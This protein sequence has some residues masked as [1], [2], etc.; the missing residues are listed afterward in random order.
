[1]GSG[2]K[3]APAP[4][5]ANP[6]IQQ[7]N[8]PTAFETI[9]N[10]RLKAFTDWENKPGARDILEAPGIGDMVDIYGSA[11]SL[12]NQKRLGNP[13]MAL[14]SGGSR[15]YA[16]QLDS[17][18]TQNRYDER[19]AGLSRGVASLKNEAYGLGGSA[20]DLESQRKNQY[21]NAMLEQQSEYYRRPKSVPLWQRIAGLAIGGVG[22]YGAA[23]GKI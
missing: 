12:A 16:K 23:G 15:D 4:P 2:G 10:Q 11:E 9:A 20:A 14:S 17:L 5:P 21:A 8:T 3:R 7:I 1:M 6:A 18:D 22:A 13:Q 19:A